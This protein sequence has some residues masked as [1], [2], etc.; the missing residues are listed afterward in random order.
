MVNGNTKIE[1][2]LYK[3]RIYKKNLYP[4]NEDSTAENTL[5][6]KN[7]IYFHD[8]SDNIT[9]VINKTITLI[10]RNISFFFLFR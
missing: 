8:Y 7:R 3:E 10:S 5:H 1:H 4:I 2:I 6:K 9:K